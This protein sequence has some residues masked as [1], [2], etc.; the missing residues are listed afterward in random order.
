MYSYE[1]LDATI[2]SGA[3]GKSEYARPSGTRAK[4]CASL[5]WMIPFHVIA[6]AIPFLGR[7]WPTIEVQLTHE[8]KS[9]HLMLEDIEDS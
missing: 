8:S 4:G 3:G 6:F 5:C 7:L 9:H 2:P 1:E